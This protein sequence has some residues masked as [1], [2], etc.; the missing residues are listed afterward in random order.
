MNLFVFPVTSGSE[1]LEP[2]VS[3]NR[4]ELRKHGT[5]DSRYIGATTCISRTT[6]WRASYKIARTLLA[7]QRPW[8]S[9][10]KHGTR[11]SRYSSTT[12]ILWTTAWR[13]SSCSY[14]FF[15]HGIFEAVRVVAG[16]GVVAMVGA[17]GGGA[18]VG[19]AVVAMVGARVVVMVV[20]AAQSEQPL[21]IVNHV[22]FVDHG[23]TWLLHHF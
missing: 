19:A 15:W 1:L 21:H 23:W 11:D 4:I 8:L 3:V 13:C 17:R 5:R 7:L 9:L 20:D 14:K 2:L 10:W 18:G 16:A 6:A 22:H 12:C